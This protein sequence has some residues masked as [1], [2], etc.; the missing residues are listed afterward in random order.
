MEKST[1]K[2]GFPTGSK[3]KS[4]NCSDCW[5]KVVL[6]KFIRHLMLKKCERL[7]ARFMSFIPIG[8]AMPSKIT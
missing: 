2:R 7:H 8:T 4:I 6:V 3:S 5:V 1:L